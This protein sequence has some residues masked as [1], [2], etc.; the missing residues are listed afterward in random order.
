[1]E[2]NTKCYHK[3]LNTDHGES[4]RTANPTQKTEINIFILMNDELHPH[5]AA[6]NLNCL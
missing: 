1:M 3:I 6:D 4:A 2:C 5:F